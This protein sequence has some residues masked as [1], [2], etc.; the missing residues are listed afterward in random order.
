MYVEDFKRRLRTYND[1]VKIRNQYVDNAPDTLESI[2]EIEASEKLQNRLK[3]LRNAGIEN[4]P[5]AGEDDVEII[6][7]E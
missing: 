5:S 1:Y 2:L 7:E 3:L 6:L 4:P